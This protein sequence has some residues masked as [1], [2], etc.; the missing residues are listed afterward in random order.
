MNIFVVCFLQVSCSRLIQPVEVYI[1]WYM[2]WYFKKD[3][4]CREHIF[5]DW[6]II[7]WTVCPSSVFGRSDHCLSSTRHV[8]CGTCL[9]IKC[10][11]LF[12]WLYAWSYWQSCARSYTQSFFVGP[13]FEPLALHHSLF[14]RSR[15]R[16]P[17]LAAWSFC[18]SR[19]RFPDPITCFRPVVSVAYVTHPH[20]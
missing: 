15:V 18:G 19:V 9:C 2:M 7:F 5:F 10:A 8:P 3:M 6:C 20:N 16:T 11:R 13:G 12:S 14:G 4:F 17:D 1:N